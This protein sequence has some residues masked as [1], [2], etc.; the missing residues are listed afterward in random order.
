[1]EPTIKSHEIDTFLHDWLGVSRTASIRSGICTSCKTT[2]ITEDTFRDAIS[3]K[4][5]TISGLCQT[6]QDDVFGEDDV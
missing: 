3:R 4:E 6:C 2:E 5:F 1:M